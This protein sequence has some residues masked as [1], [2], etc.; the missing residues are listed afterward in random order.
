MATV[1][2]LDAARDACLALVNLCGVF[3]LFVRD[4][5]IWRESAQELRSIGDE[6]IRRD[7]TRAEPYRTLLAK[8]DDTQPLAR[9]SFENVRLSLLAVAADRCGHQQI[10]EHAETILKVAS[11][12][13]GIRGRIAEL[14]AGRTLA[15]MFTAMCGP[16]ASG[17]DAWPEIDV[18]AV[19][20]RI[21]V[22]HAKALAVEAKLVDDG[23]NATLVD[24]TEWDCIERELLARLT[25]KLKTLFDPLWKHRNAAVKWK[26]LR[27]AYSG[28]KSDRAIQQALKAIPKRVATCKLSRVNVP[29]PSTV[30]RTTTVTMTVVSRPQKRAEK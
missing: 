18:Q 4:L 30:E 29:T 17:R 10:I 28:A 6:R 16:H 27:D 24:D 26:E 7:Y 11:F 2:E 13:F 12:E 22:E 15:G 9:Q 5:Y 21:E 19:R 14:D 1:S 20:Q 3:S 23:E 8:L 25:P